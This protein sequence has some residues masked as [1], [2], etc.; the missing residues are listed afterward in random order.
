M[1]QELTYKHVQKCL[2]AMKLNVVNEYFLGTDAGITFRGRQRASRIR[3]RIQAAGINQVGVLITL[4]DK[5]SEIREFIIRE[6]PEYARN[7][8]APAAAQ[9]DYE[10]DSD[11]D[12]D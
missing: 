5:H 1:S 8:V 6:F 12:H 9:R 4:C 2:R 11:Y 3:R 10:F 7:L